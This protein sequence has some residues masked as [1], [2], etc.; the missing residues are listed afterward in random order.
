MNNTLKGHLAYKGVRG[1]S[2]YELAVKNG[3]VGSEKDWLQQMGLYKVLSKYH[4]SV[5]NM[6][7]DTALEHSHLVHTLG[8]YEPNDGGAGDYIVR[9]KTADDVEDNATIYFLDNGLVAELVINNNRLNIEVFGAK[10]DGVTDCTNVFN[11]AIQYCKEKGLTLTSNRGTY[12]IS[13]DITIDTCDIDFNGGT[14]KSS[15]KHITVTNQNHLWNY[16]GTNINVF[17]NVKLHDTNVFAE[18]P[19]VILENLECID[20]HESA[21]VVN[22]VLYVDNV[23]FSNDRADVNTVSIT[24]NATDKQISRLHGK[25]GFTGIVINAQNTVIKDTQL[26]LH[27]RNKVNGTLDGSKFIH[28]KSGTGLVF[29]NC[30]S[31]TYQ[32][33]L[34]FDQSFI[35]GTL[36]NFQYIN[37]NVL[38]KNTTMYFINRYEPLI[39]TA[40]IRMTKFA[41]DNIKFYIGSPCKLNIRYFDGTPEDKTILFHGD[42]KNIL[43][44]GDGNSLSDKVEIGDGSIIKI[45]EGK[46]FA[47]VKINFPETC[48]KVV[49][50]DTSKMAGIGNVFG[51]TFIPMNSLLNG[52]DPVHGLG[53]VTK[54]SNDKLIIT[55][56]ESGWIK[57]VAFT[58][59]FELD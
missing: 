54:G 50:I 29:D 11:T 32:Y 25:G 53:N 46:L 45:N 4:N 33:G 44:D 10:G 56:W 23:V 41:D 42:I 40:L 22:Q 19:A 49:Q 57:S 1:Y 30:V 48:C 28:V 2:T 13:E 37:N 12:L 3:Y 26:W 34:Y 51:E 9:E 15:Q 35:N 58:L 24:I 5:S 17:R 36:N 16:D 27:N 38:Y 7:L 20:W 14:I 31:D 39:G 18:S 47:S 52:T 43:V 55:N 8:Y 6:K 21:I 59:E